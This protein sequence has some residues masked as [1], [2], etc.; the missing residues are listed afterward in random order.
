MDSVFNKHFWINEWEN[1]KK[2]DT[3]N[4]HQGFSTP[5]YWDKAAVTYDQDKKEVKNRRLEKTMSFLKGSG[6]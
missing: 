5:E 4:V 1:D 2:G 3:F 6:L